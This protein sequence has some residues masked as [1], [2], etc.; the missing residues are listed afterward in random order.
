MKDRTIAALIAPVVKLAKRAPV[1]MMLEDAH[2]IDPT[3]LDLTQ[4]MVEMTRDLPM[5]YVVTFR[6]EFVPRWLGRDHV[7]ALSLN[8]L[9]RDQALAMIDGVAEGKALPAE[10]LDQI[11]A[12]TDGV[13]LFIE[14]LTKSVLESELLREDDDGYVLASTLTPLA[15]PSTLHEFADGAPRPAVADQGNRADRRCDRPRILRTRCWKRS[16]RSRARRS[17]TCC[18]S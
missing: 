5:L 7:T 1:L 10:V 12:K 17:T 3:S 14:E 15:I 11:L 16:R 6:P 9:A 4:R 13:P 8:R 18:A 2:W